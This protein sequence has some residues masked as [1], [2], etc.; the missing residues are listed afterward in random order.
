MTAS[1]SSGCRQGKRAAKRRRASLLFEPLEARTLLAADLMADLDLLP[2]DVGGSSS[3]ASCAE[4]DGAGQSAISADIAEGE[5]TAEGE[6]QPDLVAFAKALDQAGAKYFGAAWCFWCT[7]QKKLFEDGGHFLPFIEVTNPDRSFNQLATDNNITSL[8]TWVFPDGTRAEG[9]QSLETLSQ[10]AGVAIPT[11]SVPTI[12]PI[13]DGTLLSGSPLHVPLDGYDPNGNPL[14]YTVTSNNPLVTPTVLQG[15]RSMRIDVQSW[16]EM[17]FELFEQR[18]PRSTARLVELA[19]S[20]FYD[21]IIFHRVIDGF[22]IQ[23]GD[24]TGTGSGGSTLGT[25]DDQFHEDLQHNR[26]GVLSHAKSGDD[27]NDSQFFGTLDATRWLDFNHS[28]SGQLAE[29]FEVLRAIGRTATGASDLPT[30]EIAMNTV[31]IF[32]DTE[33]AIVM[34]DADP[35]AIGQSADITVVAAD[36]EG[37]Q[38]QTTFHMTV[39]E[40]VAANGGA[41]GG[42]FLE[43]IADF[44]TAV[45]TAVG[46]QLSAIDVEGDPVVFEAAS[47]GSVGYTLD[48]NNQTG[49]VTVTPPSGYVGQMEVLVGVRPLNSSDTA[50]TFDQQAVTIEVIDTPTKPTLD[51]LSDS[52][53][54]DDNITNITNMTF[55]VSNAASGATVQLLNGTTVIGQGVASS[56]VDITTDALAALG[57]GTYSVT[58]VQTVSGIQSDPSDALQVTLDTTAPAFT[59]TPPTTATN[60]TAV[61]YDAE[62]SE[63]GVTYSLANAPTGA[64]IDPATGVLAWTPTAL[65]GGVQ[66]LQ[67]QA[68]DTAG[69]TAAQDLSID[70]TVVPQD[71]QI[72]LEVTDLNGTPIT[73]INSGQE[74]LLRGYVQDLRTNAEGV[75]AAY[76]DVTYNQGLVTVNG[77]DVDDITFAGAFQ[78]GKSGD[79]STAGLIDEVG[80]FGGT[81]PSGPSEKLLFDIRLSADNS[82]TVDFA[83]NPADGIGNEVLVYGDNTPV[84]WDSVTIVPASLDVGSGF[85]ANNDI[86]NVDEDSS[87][88]VLNVLA[89]DTNELGG[90]LTISAVGG[91]TNGG[92]VTIATGDT[93]LE[94][95]PATDFFGEDELTY[96]MTNGQATDTA[97]VAVQVFPQNDIPTANDDGFTVGEQSQENFL[98]VLGNDD[99]DPDQN[100]TLQVTVVG[101]PSDGGSATIAPNGTHVLYTPA[102]GFT[103]VATFDYTIGDGNGGS[104]NA[105]VTVTVEAGTVPTAVVDLVTVDEDSTQNVIDVLGNDSPT[106]GGQLTVT[107]VT[108]PASGGTVTL[109]NFGAN[110]LYNPAP[111]FFGTDTFVY[112]VDETDGGQSQ[113]TVTVTVTGVNDPPTAND[114]DLNITKDSTDNVLSVQGNDSVVP[115]AGET[116]IIT[117]VTLTSQDQGSTL[118]IS[119]DGQGIE[120]TPAAGFTGQE[121][122]T[123]SVSDRSDATGLTSQATVTVNVVESTVEVR[124]QATGDQ[125]PI[126]GLALNY[127]LVD[128]QGAV[129]SGTTDADGSLQFPATPGT[130]RVEADPLFLMP[131]EAV[132]QVASGGN[133]TVTPPTI[134]READFI[135][136][137]DFLATAPGQSDLSPDHAILAAVHTGGAHA[138]YSVEEGWVGYTGIGLQL[139]ADLSEITLSATDGDSNEVEATIS[140]NDSRVVTF[141]GQEADA[142][143]IRITADPTALDWQGCSACAGPSG[144]GE[145]AIAASSVPAV[146][147]AI[148][149]VEPS[150]TAT[151]PAEVAPPPVAPASPPADSD[152]AEGEDASVTVPTIAA[153][154][155]PVFES[156]QVQATPAQTTAIP[157]SEPDDFD[158]PPFIILTS[159][160]GGDSTV[161]APAQ[162]ES[163]T[164]PVDEPSGLSA[165]DAVLAEGLTDEGDELE[166]VLIASL[167][168]TEEYAQ[169]VDWLLA[170]EQL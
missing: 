18:A 100:E 118:A 35:S 66:T 41:N 138:W 69:N 15:N 82:G 124:V 146:E 13:E 111:N 22:M 134:G 19:Q 161:S 50:D 87:D 113:A 127:F 67:I 46:I 58:A 47:M 148:A 137:S 17:V 110:V 43:D 85:A 36:T 53:V 86:Y 30:V 70:V 154:A 140:T 157:A 75:F 151:Q 14:T 93:A 28:I 164:A 94:Y 31:D 144:E 108:Q 125:T 10:S 165:I 45:D 7:E 132:V 121:T 98:N 59:S 160:I 49:L 141:L 163:A 168:D 89:N 54:P 95:T 9:L 169:A 91:T 63:S 32:D 139:S 143:L 62:T 149:A 1:R 90:T 153:A 84:P 72:R 55:R 56:D 158:S 8:P 60:G 80:A 142:H 130:Y 119:A 48:V 6:D 29:G 133:A 33:N 74:F 101:T 11:S 106:E 105:T 88:N 34:L 97:T 83:G 117:N 145:Q 24:P 81:T 122:L 38:T 64:T 166:L 170:N 96:T 147:P 42:P 115:D 5:A 116:L 129:V 99:D 73:Q 131:I 2:D 16:G 167:S 68:T 26:E 61:T 57:D 152:A 107:G 20:D 155:T 12:A 78:N 150:V 39:L 52:N 162:F 103:G 123:Y 23:G 159:E 3:P 4:I 21:G 27:T 120:Y 65:Q 135:S 40:D 102:A 128:G 76:M 112:T 79:L 126:R 77:Q 104:D 156:V 109:G 114:D 44:T 51:L 25:F 37:N 71:A 136:V 92:T